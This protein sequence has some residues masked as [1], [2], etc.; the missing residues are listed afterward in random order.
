MSEPT[1]GVVQGSEAVFPKAEF[2]RRMA[3]AREAAAARGIDVLVVTGP[4]NIFYL[5]GQQTPGYYTFQAFLLPVESEPLFLLRQLERLN[6]LANSFIERAETYQDNQMPSEALVGLLSN[7]GWL[8]RRIAIEKRGWF[9]PITFY[10]QL[11]DRIERIE[12]GSGVVEA[13]RMVKSPAEIEAIERAA[14]YA[15]AGIAAGLAQVSDGHSENHVVAAVMQAA[16]GSGS[17]YMGMEPLVSSGPRG[18]IPHA[19]WRRRIM[20]AGDGAFLEMAGCHNRYHAALMR[21]AWLGAPP[22]EAR[23]MMDACLEG[24][25]A[26]LA[27]LKP[28]ATCEAVHNACQTVIDRCGYTENYRKRTGYSIG[29]SFAPDWGEGNVLSLFTGVHEEIRP[30][31][32]FHIPPALRIYGRFTVGVS[33]TVVVT[34]DGCRTLSRLPRDLVEV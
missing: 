9:L 11:R 32:T 34:Q 14:S 19:T 2:E 15:D 1:T 8:S 28:G 31:M 27:A 10:D 4:E 20:Q 25:D 12:D 29:T 33:E 23:R 22:P 17:E 24:L 26:A 7:L 5:T 21:S 13:L 30:G 3:A 16:I 6:C 18:G